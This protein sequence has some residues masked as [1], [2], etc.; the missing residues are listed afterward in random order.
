MKVYF[1]AIHK[2]NALYVEWHRSAVLIAGTTQYV[3]NKKQFCTDYC[4]PKYHQKR[5]QQKKLNQEGNLQF[6]EATEF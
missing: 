4:M 5:L 6:L 1:H 2:C 3:C